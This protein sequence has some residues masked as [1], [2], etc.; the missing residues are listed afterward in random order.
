MRGVNK[1]FL[2]GNLGADPELR[3][4]Q[5]GKEVV[6]LSVATNR[7]VR[8]GEGWA[9]VAEWHKIVLFDHQARH[10]SERLS[11]GDAVGVVGD[12]RY[13]KWTD[14]DGKARSTTEII[15]QSVAY[16]GSASRR[17]AESVSRPRQL[18][19]G[20]AIPDAVRPADPAAAVSEAELPF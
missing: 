9:E 20:H 14:R 11:K 18:A 16:L 8:E 17:S 2:I 13:R 10:A 1:V 15:A 7:P 3:I 4:T 12:L 19:A 6:R 5:G